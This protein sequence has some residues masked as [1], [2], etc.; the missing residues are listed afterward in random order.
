MERDNKEIKFG[1]IGSIDTETMSTAPKHLKDSAVIDNE[2]YKLEKLAS[3]IKFLT[4][5]FISMVVIYAAIYAMAID[6]YLVYAVVPFVIAYWLSVVRLSWLAYGPFMG[7][8]SIVAI[9][10]PPL[11]LLFMI[12]SYSRASKYIKNQ[13]GALKF[14]GALAK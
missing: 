13:G 9:A 3:A 5:S 4:I 1:D 6:S 8:I 11:V 14:S 12:L 2:E 7:A 10:F